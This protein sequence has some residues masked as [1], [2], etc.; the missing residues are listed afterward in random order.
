MLS[1]VERMVLECAWSEEGHVYRILAGEPEGKRLL[2]RT[3]HRWEVNI[4]VDL[5]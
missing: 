3:L 4:N 2:V 1:V 5:R